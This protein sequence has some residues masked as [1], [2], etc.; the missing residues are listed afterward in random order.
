[1]RIGCNRI[2][3]Q[4]VARSL[5]LKKIEGVYDECT[6]RSTKLII[7][8]MNAKVCT[9]RMNRNR[10]LERIVFITDVMVTH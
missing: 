8:D 10:S 5:L 2:Q 1:M 7:S 9:E 6:R 3:R 4:R